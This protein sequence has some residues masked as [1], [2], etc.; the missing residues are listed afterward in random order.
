MSVITVCKR[1]TFGASHFLPDYDGPCANMHGHNF[2]LEIEV[3]L[4]ALGWGQSR[5][6]R[7]MVIDFKELKKIV[8]ANI[9]DK[10]DHTVLN[11][12][13]PDMVPTAENLIFRFLSI[14]KGKFQKHGCWIMRMKLHET[15]S[16]FAEWREI[17]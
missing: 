13:F 4:K 6:K 8:E 9:I 14:L 15:E 10:V 7:N 17:S 12:V 16:S 5:T 2:A 1:F 3:G 11:E